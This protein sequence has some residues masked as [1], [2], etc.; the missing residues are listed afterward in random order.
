MQEIAVA[1][2]V[3]MIFQACHSYSCNKPPSLASTRK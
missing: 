2:A 1:T 3:N